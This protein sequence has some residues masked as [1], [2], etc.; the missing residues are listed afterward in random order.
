[1][2]TKLEE[3]SNHRFFFG[4]KKKFVNFET[5]IHLYVFLELNERGIK[6][7]GIFEAYESLSEQLDT[8]YP[9]TNVILSTQGNKIIADIDNFVFTADKKKQ[10]YLKEIIIPLAK[11]VEYADNE[12]TRF[13]PLGKRKSVVIDPRIQMG[14]PVLDGTRINTKVI[15]Q[16]HEAGENHKVISRMYNI[17]TKQI[18]DAVEFYSNAA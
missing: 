18:R 13:F 11:K 16:L 12:I 5:L 3:S 9:F 8:P 2:Q 4:E 7:R 10:G 17:S 15:Y 1:M 6:Y 14:S